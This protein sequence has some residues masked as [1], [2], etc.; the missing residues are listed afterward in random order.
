MTT[1]NEKINNNLDE[2][3]NDPFQ[4]S[5]AS[6]VKGSYQNGVG[7]GNL[8]SYGGSSSR[9]SQNLSSLLWQMP[10]AERKSILA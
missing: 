4:M 9:Y 3:A 10:Y 5:Q 6:M 7:D 8:M 2:G 1:P